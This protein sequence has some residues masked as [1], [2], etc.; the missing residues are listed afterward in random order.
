MNKA[1]LINHIAEQH[2]C[3][4]IEAEKAIN[5][6]TSGITSAVSLGNDISLIG[7][8]NFTVS[9]VAARKGMNLK[10]KEP[11]DIPAYKQVRFKVGSTLKNAA[12]GKSATS[13]SKKT[14]SRDANKTATKGKAGGAGTRN[15]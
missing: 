3:T 8:G 1:E 13:N 6:F 11:I 10:T 5:M 15:K 14:K 7:F 2:N 12:N 9:E 4:K